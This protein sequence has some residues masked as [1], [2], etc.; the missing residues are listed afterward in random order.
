MRVT[1]I[2]PAKQH[3]TFSYKQTKPDPWEF[4]TEKYSVGSAVRGRIVNITNFGAFVELEKG[5]E[6]LIHISELT[7]RSIQ[8]PEEVVSIDEE[9]NLK[10]IKRDVEARRIYLSLKA[11]CEEQPSTI[12]TTETLYNDFPPAGEKNPKG[13]T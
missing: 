9:L 5:I 12:G 7:S 13:R 2:D 8:T 10:V 6:G 3:F 11:M 1:E 4:I